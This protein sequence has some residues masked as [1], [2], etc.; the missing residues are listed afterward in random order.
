MNAPLE[1]LDTQ[2]D[3]DVLESEYKRLLGFPAAYI[4]E[5]RSRE[6]ADWARDWYAKHGRPWIYARQMPFELG[7]ANVRLNGT[8]LTSKR[9]RDQLHEADAT[10]AVLTA[11]SAGAECEEKARELWLEGK[12]DE[13]FFLEIYGSAVVE[14]LVTRAGARLCAWAESRG[15]AI[16]PHYSPGYSG[17]DVR[18]QR[19]LFDAICHG[20]TQRFPREIRV[21]DSG[22]LQPKKALLAVFGCT[23]RLDKVRNLAALIPCEN[24]SFSPCQFRRAPFRESL[25]GLEDVSRL[26]PNRAP[27]TN[28]APASAPLNL[29]ASY[30][31]NARA[32]RKWSSERLRLRALD[33]GGFEANFRYEGTTCSNL[34]R[35][36]LCDYRITLG[37]RET[38]YLV[39]DVF[40]VRAPEDTG[41]VHMCEY[42]SNGDALLSRMHEEKP[43][44]GKPL[45]QLLAW[46]RPYS[47]AA[48]YCNAESRNHKWGLV[49][50]VIHYTLAER[51]KQTAL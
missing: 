15:A 35:S 27:M 8:S 51:E 10:E 41:F 39:K 48:C 13:Y 33:D 19:G 7:D 32:L 38:G 28:G 24:C 21:L 45:D 29:K 1:F 34:G 23:N 42:L 36:I 37:S 9:L 26:Q 17:W 47:P 18:D 25:P 44:L 30:T 49:L 11:I 20:P 50:E 5:D 2:P 46:T 16:L 40:C 31:V 3:V 12:P 6:L 4:L 43:L 22:M 14:H